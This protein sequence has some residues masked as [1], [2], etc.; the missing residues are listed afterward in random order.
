MLDSD[1]IFSN[2]SDNYKGL[3]LVFKK[4]D[5]FACQGSVL[6]D[7]FLFVSYFHFASFCHLI[8]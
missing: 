4:K 1:I 7:G 3:T 8:C 6:L 2:S 5:M